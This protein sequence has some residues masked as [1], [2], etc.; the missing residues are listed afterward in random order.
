MPKVT[1]QYLDARREHILSAARR[2]F[3]RDGFHATS[4]QDLFAEAGL[5]SGAVYRYFPSK[6]DLIIA[7][8]AENLQDVVAMIHTVATQQPGGSVGA[9]MA[10]VLS[11]VR[12]KHEQDGLG[13]LAVLVWAEVLRDPSLARQFTGLVNQMRADVTEVVRAH[14]SSGDLTCDVAPE[15]V[16]TVLMSIVPGYILQ[17]TLLGSAAVEGATE[18][19]RALSFT[20]RAARDPRAGTAE[21][22]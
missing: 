16:A 5:S 19:V 8:A 14:Q 10:D 2:C 1:Q 3:L 22:H 21:P 9:M 12:A 11:M 7:I 13:G 18:A 17:L 4:M 20:A 6:D 15:A